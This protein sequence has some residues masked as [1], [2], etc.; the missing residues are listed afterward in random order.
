MVY[1]FCRKFAY[2]FYNDIYTT[3]YKGD[4]AGKVKDSY[5]EWVKI[6]ITSNQEVRK[7]RDKYYLYRKSTHYDK[8]LGRSKSKTECYL[9]RIT[10]EY[11]LIPKGDGRKLP[12]KPRARKNPPVIT[13]CDNLEYGITYWLASAIKPLYYSQIEKHFGEIWQYVV[14]IA[15]TRLVYQSPIC[16]MQRH[17]SHSFLSQVFPDVNLSEENVR[18]VLTYIGNNREI[19]VRY[20]R[21]YIKDGDNILFDGTD[22]ECMSR[23]VTYPQKSKTKTGKFTEAVGMML[24]FSTSG[25]CPVYFRNLPGDIKDVAAIK[26]CAKEIDVALFSAVMDKGFTSTEN[27]NMLKE[28]NIN[29]I[30]PL[31]RSVNIDYSRMPSLNAITADGCFRY[32]GRSIL[33]VRTADYNGCPTYIYLDD[34]LR[35]KESEDATK[36]Y[37]DG[38]CKLDEDYQ[39]KM[40]ELTRSYEL[41]KKEKRVVH[42]SE[43]FSDKPNCPEPDIMEHV[44]FHEKSVE[45]LKESFAEHSRKFGTIALVASDTSLSPER[46]YLKY[47]QRGEVEQMIDSFKNVLSADRSYMQNQYVYDGWMQCNFIALQWY[48]VMRRTIMEKKMINHHS[49]QSIMEQLQY[50]HIVKVNGNWT[51]IERT[52][53]REDVLS[54]L[55]ISITYDK[56]LS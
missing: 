55:G 51:V 2:V 39:K 56:Y 44:E 10:E 38:L 19:C 16:D 22:A 34:D 25:Y 41:D 23:L 30:L 18:T 8:E 50:C 54:K 29:F 35:H 45:K 46:I 13:V 40:E 32:E 4:M 27:M 5:P 33:Y 47:K 7:V 49:V 28:C 42:S 43:H 12:R 52:K 20:L 15:Y 37:I 3:Y 24:G 9:G 11:G 26:L 48:Y 6:H 21:E 53:K 1:Y 14:A 31:K 36:R 17:F